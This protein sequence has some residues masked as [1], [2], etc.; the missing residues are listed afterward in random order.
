MITLRPATQ[1]DVLPLASAH[2][3]A[4]RETYQGIVPD[5]VLAPLDPAKRAAMWRG[6]V[7]G[8]GTVQLGVDAEGIAGFAD[9]GAQRDASLSFAGEIYAIYV[10]RRAQRRG[11]GR[12]LMG[13]MAHQLALPV[14]PAPVFGSPRRMRRPGGSMR[15]LA[16]GWWAS[17]PKPTDRNAGGLAA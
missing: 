9:A 14:F 7:E 3:Q 17:G 10:L 1:A 16:A 11:L 13:A 12:R 5:H 2:V 8:G 6:R 4:W 15:R